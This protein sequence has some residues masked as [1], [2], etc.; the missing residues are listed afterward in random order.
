MIDYRMIIDDRSVSSHDTDLA[1]VGVEL[2]VPGR[3]EGS[4]HIQ[5]L[6]VQTELQ[7]LRCSVDNLALDVSSVRLNLE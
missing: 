5:S 1:H 4:G 7:H 3:E 6:T 2:L